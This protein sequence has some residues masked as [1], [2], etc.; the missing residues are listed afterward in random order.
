M[1]ALALA[2]AWWLAPHVMNRLRVRRRVARAR[3]GQAST[4]DATLLYLRMLDLLRRH[5]HQKP[6]WYTPQEFAATLPADLRGMVAEFTAAYNA[7]R[8]GG[9]PQAAPQLTSLLDRL[10]GRHA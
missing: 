4:A 1:A 7:V 5:G 8:F 3:M 10:E 6:A 2:L 9:D